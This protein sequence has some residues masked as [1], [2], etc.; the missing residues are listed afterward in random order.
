MEFC[1]L[2]KS[3]ANLHD[4]QRRRLAAVEQTPEGRWRNP[5]QL[6]L[7]EL[8]RIIQEWALARR[9]RQLSLIQQGLWR[10]AAGALGAP[11][12][13]QIPAGEAQRTAEAERTRRGRQR[14]LHSPNIRGMRCCSGSYF[15][16]TTKRPWIKS[17]Q[18]LF[19]VV[20]ACCPCAWVGFGVWIEI[21]PLEK[22]FFL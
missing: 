5:E 12:S 4:E 16:L 19:C 6:R 15:G 22:I 9:W 14:D 11:A 17:H 13:I 2:L 3:G 10:K 20:F 18:G 8:M 1:S 21:L 7:S